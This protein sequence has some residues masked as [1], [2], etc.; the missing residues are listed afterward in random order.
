[1]ISIVSEE[2]LAK[3]TQAHTHT[4]AR[5]HT[6][7]Q[8]QVVYVK[9]HHPPHTQKKVSN[10]L[11]SPPPSTKNPTTRSTSTDH[12]SREVEYWVEPRRMSGGRY[13]SVTTSWEYV[14]LGMDLA[15]A[16]PEHD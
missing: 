5:T 1:M 13:H 9:K 10:P 6:H 12:M 2:S 3:D 8:T 11:P 7:T 16:R 14:W 4:H 15:R